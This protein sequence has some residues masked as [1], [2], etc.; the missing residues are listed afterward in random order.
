MVELVQ[1]YMKKKNNYT[2]PNAMYRGLVIDMFRED[3]F[4]ACKDI[5]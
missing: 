5:E 2:K 3:I 4:Y 1:G